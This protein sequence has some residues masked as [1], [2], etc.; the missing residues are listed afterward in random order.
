MRLC[1][2]NRREDKDCLYVNMNA[3]K[4]FFFFFF[5]WF[6]KCFMRRVLYSTHFLHRAPLNQRKE[7]RCKVT[8]YQKCNSY[9]EPWAAGLGLGPHSPHG[10]KGR[11]GSSSSTQQQCNQHSQNPT[12][13]HNYLA[14]RWPSLLILAVIN[15]D[16][17]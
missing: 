5:K 13:S 8:L 4:T 11:K 7:K 14:F 3:N 9:V 6:C 1:T 12:G 2:N 16:P 17:N 10:L 15:L